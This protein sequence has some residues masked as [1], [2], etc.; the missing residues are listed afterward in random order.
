VLGGISS[1]MPLVVRV[2]VKPVSSI[3]QEQA[4]V[5]LKKM[6][7]ATL[8]VGGR[9]DVCVVPRAVVVVEAM[10]AITLCDFALR[11]GLI[12]RVLK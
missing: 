4:T 1:G 6:E 8:K 3:A 10:L 12:P 9:H 2:A 7:K 11:E 5:D